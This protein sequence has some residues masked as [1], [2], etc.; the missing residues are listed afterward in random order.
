MAVPR[1]CF[2]PILWHCTRCWLL[3]RDFWNSDP[4]E[5]DLR[6]YHW[7]LI[8]FYTWMYFWVIANA[9]LSRPSRHQSLQEHQNSSSYFFAD[10]SWCHFDLSFEDWPLRLFGLLWSSWNHWSAVTAEYLW[11]LG[12]STRCGSANSWGLGWL[13]IGLPRRGFVVSNRMKRSTWTMD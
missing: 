13:R 3:L 6:W 11:T 5:F 10:E 7:F 12:S 8:D 4:S 2:R 9:H 1:F